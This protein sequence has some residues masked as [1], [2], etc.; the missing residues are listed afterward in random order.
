MRAPGSEQ[1][2]ARPKLIDRPPAEA[3]EPP[4]AL[5]QRVRLALE[6]RQRLLEQRAQLDDVLERLVGRVAHLDAVARDRLD[7]L[8]QRRPAARHRTGAPRPSA[9]ARGCT[10]AA[11]LP[12][13]S[14]ASIARDRLDAVLAE[15][16]EDADEPGAEL[17]CG[18]ARRRPNRPVVLPSNDTVLLQWLVALACAQCRSDAARGKRALTSRPSSTRPRW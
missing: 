1:R 13:A 7:R 16:A 14:P 9:C 8:G 11:A 18:P 10:S 12:R 3:A 6:Q 4:A 5:D 17:G 2:Q 15:I